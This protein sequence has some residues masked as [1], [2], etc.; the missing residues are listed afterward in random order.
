[1][2]T[3]SRIRRLLVLPIALALLMLQVPVM[4]DAAVLK[5]VPPSVEMRRSKDVWTLPVS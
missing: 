1:M 3:T 4:A 5:V 2:K